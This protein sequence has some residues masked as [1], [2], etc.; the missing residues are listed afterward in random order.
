M[1]YYQ[2]NNHGDVISVLDQ[3]G[4]IKNEY[5]YDAFGNAITEKETVSNPYR[6]AGYY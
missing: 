2:Y 3:A 4:A 5:D 6:Y 1:L